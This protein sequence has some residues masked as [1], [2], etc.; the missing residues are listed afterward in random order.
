MPSYEASSN[1]MMYQFFPGELLTQGSEGVGVT[2]TKSPFMNPADFYSNPERYEYRL[3]ACFPD[4]A[5]ELRAIPMLYDYNNN[6]RFDLPEFGTTGK[7]LYKADRT[8]RTTIIYNLLEFLTGTQ[9][10]QSADGEIATIVG[11]IL[12]QDNKVASGTLTSDGATNKFTTKSF[13]GDMT[14]L[15]GTIAKKTTKAFDGAVSSI[16]GTLTINKLFG[17]LVEGTLTSSGAINNLISKIFGGTL[18]SSGTMNRGVT[19]SFSGSI[20]S[21]VGTLNNQRNKLFSGSLSSSGGILK[22]SNKTLDG[23]NTP[24]GILSKLSNKFF[25]GT[26]TS[27]GLLDV[28]R[29]FIKVLEGVL[30]SLGTISKDTLKNTSGTFVSSG[31]ISKI[32]TK[33]FSGTLSLAGQIGRGF[34]KELSGAI[35]SIVGTLSTAFNLITTVPKIFL[36]GSRIMYARLSGQTDYYL[37]LLGDFDKII[38]LLGKKKG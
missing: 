35:T 13:S 6:S 15:I 26:L 27:S 9:Y 11:T 21:I 8:W 33:L 22:Q 10:N 19:K 29:A 4:H 5:N 1:S 37:A 31:T 14:S 28:T 36:F 24:S 23:S 30:S 18:T 38:N 25:A 34:F 16:V 2:G 12:K 20:S 17:K 32:T 3:D 7:I